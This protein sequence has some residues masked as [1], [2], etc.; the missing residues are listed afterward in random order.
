ML[1][2]MLQPNESK[3]IIEYHFLSSTT[4][5]LYSDSQM[6]VPME[7]LSSVPIQQPQPSHPLSGFIPE[8]PVP[9]QTPVI[10]GQQPVIP[11][12]TSATE[13][14]PASDQTSALEENA[15]ETL[16]IQNLNEKVKPQGLSFPEV[17]VC[18]LT[19][20]SDSDES[21]TSRIVQ[22]LWRSS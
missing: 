20:R 5:L 7:D 12:Q 19:G 17:W 10:P 21:D 18:G 4:G 13:A 11:G 9:G 6:D 3:Y 14:L 2:S 16:Y 15:C 1:L 8:P 22:V